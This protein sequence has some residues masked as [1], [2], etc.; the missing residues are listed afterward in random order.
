MSFSVEYQTLNCD[1]DF[2]FGKSNNG[3][4][5]NFLPIGTDSQIFPPV[6][7]YL[8]CFKP[9]LKLRLLYIRL[10]LKMQYKNGTD[11]MFLHRGR[12]GRMFIP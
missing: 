7:L 3:S 10:G 2:A 1:E 6:T 9:L 4:L 11:A 5:S 8:E 12:E